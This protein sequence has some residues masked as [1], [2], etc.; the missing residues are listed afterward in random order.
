MAQVTLYMPE[1]LLEKLRGRARERGKSLS[2]YVVEQLERRQSGRRWPAGF[3]DLYGSWEGPLEPPDDPAP[4][5][6]DRLR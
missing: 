5:E 6:P 1:A 3:E 2:A 4:E